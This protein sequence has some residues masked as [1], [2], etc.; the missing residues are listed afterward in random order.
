MKFLPILLVVFTSMSASSQVINF[1]VLSRVFRLRYEFTTNSV[2]TTNL[3]RTTNTGSSFTIEIDHKQYLITAKHIVPGIRDGGLVKI[4]R[5]SQWHAFPVKVISCSDT[6]VD[7]TV[8]ILP[9]QISPSPPLDLGVADM[10]HGQDMYFLGFPYGMYLDAGDLNNNFPLPFIRKGVLSSWQPARDKNAGAIWIS[11]QNN[12][13]FSGGP[14]VFQNLVKQKLAIAGVVSGYR[15]NWDDIFYKDPATNLLLKA[16]N[17]VVAG[18]SGL[19]M[20][21]SLQSA[22][23]AIAKRPDGPPVRSP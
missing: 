13:G 2:A 21:W 4:F 15:S 22:L 12:P 16:T 7:I 10:I 1:N 19:T 11:E 23:D 17:L 6:N 9:S 14:I 3:V 8:L 18:N 5:E 20:G